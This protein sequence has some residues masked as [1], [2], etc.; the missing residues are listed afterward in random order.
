MQ[1]YVI[2]SNSRNA[3]A[4]TWVSPNSAN[5][6]KVENFSP[7]GLA[8]GG[9][10]NVVPTNGVSNS[11]NAY[12]SFQGGIAESGNI[13]GVAYS[14]P[15]TL[16]PSLT[17]LDRVGNPVGSPLQVGTYLTN[18]NAIAG[19]PKGFVYFYPNNSKDLE[20]VFLPT[21]GDASVVAA[22]PAAG[23][24]S[25]TSVNPG[26]GYA[27]GGS[28]C[29]DNVGPNATGGVGVAVFY[30]QGPTFMYLNPDGTQPQS[31]TQVVA[32]SMA[33]YDTLSVTSFNGRFL[34]SLRSSVAM[35]TQI[36]ANG[37]P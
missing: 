26:S 6:L 9:N 29:M 30:D 35:S 20:E 32:H 19:T 24:F 36:F 27:Q 25:P 37:C 4:F 18:W 34:V 16:Y 14:D 12:N 21:S 33:T 22:A 5:T 31:P 10:T 2:W 3:F 11:V 1:P 7:E 28:A 17:V 8:V 15:K 23:P 13:L